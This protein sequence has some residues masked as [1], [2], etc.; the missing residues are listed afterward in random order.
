MALHPVLQPVAGLIGTW[1]GDGF[2]KYPTIQDF[3]YREELTFADIGK[4]F[5]H[6]AQRTWAPDGRPL[7]VETGYL[8]IPGDGR[9]EFIIAQPTGQTELAEGRLRV[10]DAVE[11]HLEGRIQNSGSAKRVDA[12]VRTYRLTGDTLSTT[13]DMAAV[14]QPIVRHLESSLRRTG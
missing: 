5:L 7:H 6:Y 2:G 1:E 10:D 12:T 4:P 3:H 14:G 8:R 9:A 11:L 13:F